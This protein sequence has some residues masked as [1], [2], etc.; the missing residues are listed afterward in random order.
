MI[1]GMDVGVFIAWIGT[2]L[3]AVLCI[4]YGVY[5]RLKKDTEEK[6]VKPS[7]EPSKLTEEP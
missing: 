6:P 3:A 5:Y 2:I 4:L 1:L 7:K